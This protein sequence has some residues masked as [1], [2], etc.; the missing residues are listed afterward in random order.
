MRTWVLQQMEEK[1]YRSLVESA[2]DKRYADFLRQVAG[3]SEQ[4]EKEESEMHKALTKQI[5]LQNREQAEAK[6]AARAQAMA[7]KLHE[8]QQLLERTNADP[9]LTEANDFVMEGT[10]R[11]RR[12][13]FRGYTSGQRN[14]IFKENADLMRERA[15]RRKADKDQERLWAAQQESWR[16]QLEA[17]EWE[18]KQL[19]KQVALEQQDELLAQRQQHQ[20]RWVRS[21]GCLPACLPGHVMC[22]DGW[23]L[24]RDTGG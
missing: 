21:R 6:L 20:S 17:Q 24:L 11:I 7:A 13:H 19:R 10:G 12:D 8:D 16:R 4:Q 23:V 15:E 9:V 1:R 3:M 18:E 2:E 5:Q 22:G 14:L